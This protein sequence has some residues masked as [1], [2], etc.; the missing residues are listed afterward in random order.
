MLR[1]DEQFD[2]LVLYAQ[3]HDINARLQFMR[4][5]HTQTIVHTDS[6]RRLLSADD[7]D[8]VSDESE[9]DYY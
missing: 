3:L 4:N 2:P 5:A 7:Y 9:D 1:G 8:D 6:P